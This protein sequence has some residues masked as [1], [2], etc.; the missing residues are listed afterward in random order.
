MVETA[1][2]D[3][4]GVTHWFVR[5]SLAEMR[6]VLKEIEVRVEPG[7][8]VCLVGPSGCGKTTLLN[9]IAGVLRPARGEIDVAISG[10]PVATPDKRV[11]YMLARDTLLPWRTCIENVELGLELRGVAKAERREEAKIALEKVGLGHALKLYPSEL[12]QGMR[13]RANLARTLV[14]KPVLLLMDEP[15]GALDALTR[16][17]MQG[18]FLQ[19]WERDQTSVVFVTHDLQEAALLGDRV[20]AMVAGRIVKEVEVPFARPRIPDEL[21]FDGAFQN[22]VRE[23]WLTIATPAR[24]GAVESPGN[25]ELHQKPSP[26]KAEAALEQ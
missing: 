23:L 1:R 24:P 20:I 6:P 4:R 11:G 14:T 8:F 16:E 2:V 18:E 13:Q 21:R 7:E 19:I 22:V 3:V 5:D 12:S 26:A 9:M 25:G 15:F 17:L 10:S